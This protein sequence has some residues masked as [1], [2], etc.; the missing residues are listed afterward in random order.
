MGL[1]EAGKKHSQEH[2]DETKVTTETNGGGDQS[3]LLFP[4]LKLPRLYR[5][6]GN[7]H[8]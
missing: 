4:R 2:S 8:Y 5:L 3:Y 1:L 7:Y 6:V